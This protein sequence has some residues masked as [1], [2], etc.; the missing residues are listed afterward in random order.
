MAAPTHEVCPCSVLRV[1]DGVANLTSY[2]AK[3]ARVALLRLGFASF[4]D[5]PDQGQGAEGADDYA[6]EETGCKG[7]S[8]EALLCLN[9]CGCWAIGSLGCGGGAS[10]GRRCVCG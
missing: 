7:L 1:V 9:G 4:L 2:M 6:R 8:V 10:G 3:V 5:D